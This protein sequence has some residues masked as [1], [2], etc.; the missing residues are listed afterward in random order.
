MIDSTYETVTP[1]VRDRINRIAILVPMDLKTLLVMWLYAF[2]SHISYQFRGS[3][4]L[5]VG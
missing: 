1:A 2:A 5:S 3:F 4:G